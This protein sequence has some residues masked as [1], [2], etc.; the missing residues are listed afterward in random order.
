MGTSQCKDDL[1]DE[2]EL[3]EMNEPDVTF[4]YDA[5]NHIVENV[6]S[7]MPDPNDKDAPK[8]K[9]LAPRRPKQGSEDPPNKNDADE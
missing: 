4:L 9:R 7:T 8:P 1:E 2:R 5:K 3:Y 6:P